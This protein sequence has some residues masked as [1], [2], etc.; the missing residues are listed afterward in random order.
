MASVKRQDFGLEEPCDSRCSAP[1][2]YIGAHFEGD[3]PRQ[4]NIVFRTVR[5]AQMLD[6]RLRCDA[7]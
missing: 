5:V 3:F 2:C 1:V 7:R 6:G 4:S